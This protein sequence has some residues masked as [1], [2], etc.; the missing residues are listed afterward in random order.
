MLQV[1]TSWSEESSL[2]DTLSI[3]GDLALHHAMLGGTHGAAIGKLIEERNFKALCEYELPLSHPDWDTT[4]LF[5][6]RQ[7][8][9]LF[10]KLEALDVGVDKTQVAWEKFKRSEDK[11]KSIND[12]FRAFSRGLASLPARD[13]RVLYAARRKIKLALGR[14]PEIWELPLRL[15]PGATTS[16]TKINACPQMKFAAGL[17]CSAD[18]LASGL[19]PSLLRELPHW[20]DEFA[21]SDWW[22]FLDD[23]SAYY[24]C[25]YNV[26]ITPGKL[27]FVPKNALTHR[28]IVVEPILSGMLQMGIGD[29][30]VDRLRRVGLDVRNDQEKHGRLAYASSLSGELATLDLSSASDTIANLLVKFLLPER[31]FHLLSAARSGTVV[32]KKQEIVLEKFSSMGNGYTFPLETLIFWALSHASLPAAIRD[33]ATVSVYGDDIIV[34]ACAVS[35]V[36]RTLEFCGFSINTEKSFSEG[37][38]RESCGHDYFNG[39]DVCPCKPKNLASGAS[40]FVLHN[41][42]YR[43]GLWAFAEK[44]KSYIPT[45]LRIYGPDGYGDGHLLADDW[46]RVRKPAHVKNGYAGYVFDTFKY[47]TR[48]FVSIYPGDHVSPLY[49][50]YRKAYIEAAPSIGFFDFPE[51]AVVQQF[52]K[53]GRPIWTLPG[54]DGYTRTSI[55]TLN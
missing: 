14:C 5:H 17:H 44:V 40:L 13:V 42:Y 28:S 7:A 39:I 20:S 9:S 53:S 54:T 3:H 52:T 38:F 19:L 55:Y 29:F 8:Q 34:P 51:E 33:T 31:W 1:S 4:Q 22:E 37:P 16:I 26:A 11:C 43:R 36:I 23:G 27:A 24:G 35:E 15:G 32:Y 41:F 2:D 21:V 6:A 12:L 47:G 50:I 30:L 18:L 10:K 46:P 25:D 45:E 48:K 49:S